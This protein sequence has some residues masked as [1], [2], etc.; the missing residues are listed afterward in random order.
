MTVIPYS[1][2]K[3]TSI[4][5]SCVYT[6]SFCKV[7]ATACGHR[8]IQESFDYLFLYFLAPNEKLFKLLLCHKAE[9]PSW[10]NFHISSC[11]HLW[12]IGS[13][14]SRGWPVEGWCCLHSTWD[15]RQQC[16]TGSLHTVPGS[17]PEP[18]TCGED[19]C[20]YWF[21]CCQ[22]ININSEYLKC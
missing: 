13:T 8:W 2:L 1:L 18:S 10:L 17:T 4:C 16:S 6:H 21:L 15:G 11:S 12:H 19:F 5:A 20:C 22:N 9:K 14:T 3:V 7:L